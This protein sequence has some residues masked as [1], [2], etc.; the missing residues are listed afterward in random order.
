MPTD[1]PEIGIAAL[2]GPVLVDLTAHRRSAQVFHDSCVSEM[3]LGDHLSQ[4]TEW[5]DS[6]LARRFATSLLLV[7]TVAGLIALAV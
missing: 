5:V 6:L 3:D 4:W 1:S 7:G 2:P